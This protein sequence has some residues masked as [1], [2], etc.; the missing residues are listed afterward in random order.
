MPATEVCITIDTEFSIGGAFAHPES[1]RPIGEERVTCPANGKENGLGFLLACFERFGI[2]ATFFIEALN[3]AYFG[4]APMGRVAERILRGGHDA[5]LH[6][7]P[8]WMYFRHADWQQRLTREK[9]ND[10]CDGR[11]VDEIVGMISTGVSVFAQWGAPR[12][13][14]LRTGNLRV[15]ANVHAAMSAAGIFIGSNIGAGGRF[16]PADSNLRVFG[17]RRRF[18]D[19]LE[20]PILTYSQLKLGQR[21][22]HRLLTITS[23]SW[24]E[25]KWLLWS[26]RRQGVS[27]II[28]LTH[29]FEFVKGSWNSPLRLSRNR[30]NQSRLGKLCRFIAENPRE[31]TSSTFRSAAPR[32]LSEPD[33]AC[34]DITVPLPFAVARMATNKCNDLFSFM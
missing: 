30:T 23:T 20:L 16:A 3:A 25:M 9:P 24:A 12:P 7:H 11:R 19:V 27:Q 31:F 21:S 10:N 8:C 1:R 13:I 2:K 28:V 14:A 34:P 15:D 33:Q 17:G 32:W 6:L 29:P 22:L 18:G 26:A 4:D 5:Q